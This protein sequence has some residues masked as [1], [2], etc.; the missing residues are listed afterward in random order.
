MIFSMH[1]INQI[2]AWKM[3][4]RVLRRQHLYARKKQQK[5]L[6]QAALR[7]NLHARMRAPLAI[8]LE[9]EAALLAGA[10]PALNPRAVAQQKTQL[11]L[12]VWPKMVAS[13]VAQDG[14]NGSQ[15]APRLGAQEAG[16]AG[17][18]HLAWSD[19]QG[20]ATQGRATRGCRQQEAHL[21]E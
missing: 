19:R 9:T 15:E 21:L 1:I 8:G 11:G 14:Q 2:R 17:Q 3:V 18:S 16:R 12:G 13:C 4:C 7:R 10:A 5:A 6:R 20:R